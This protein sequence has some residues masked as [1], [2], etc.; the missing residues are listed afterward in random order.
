MLSEYTHAKFPEGSLTASE[1]PV[2]APGEMKRVGP[3]WRP[4][5]SRISYLEKMTSQPSM[6]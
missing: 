5:E 2:E 4:Q 1:C 6:N 3:L